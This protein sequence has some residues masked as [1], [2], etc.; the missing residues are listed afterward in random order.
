M[1]YEF[2]TKLLDIFNITSDYLNLKG[3]SKTMTKQEAKKILDGLK[4]G[5]EYPMS[6]I[7]EALIVSGDM[8]PH[9]ETSNLKTTSGGY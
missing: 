3:L 4:G 6:V 5:H 1:T 2:V 9:E 8:Q 7:T